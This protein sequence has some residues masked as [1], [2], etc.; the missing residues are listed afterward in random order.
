M[1]SVWDS[2]NSYRIYNGGL[3]HDDLTNYLKT[4]LKR[5]GWIKSQGKI[6]DSIFAVSSELWFD[7]IP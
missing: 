2:L 3:T 4:I 1:V 6:A 7:P 5:Q